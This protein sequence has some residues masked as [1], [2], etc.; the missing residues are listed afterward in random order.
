MYYSCCSY[1]GT[2]LKVDYTSS[3]FRI[4]QLPDHKGPK[5]PTDRVAIISFG[6]EAIRTALSRSDT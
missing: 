1:D 4:A 6:W 5:R 2:F 3:A